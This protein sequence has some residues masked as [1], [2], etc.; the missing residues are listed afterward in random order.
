MDGADFGLD[1]DHILLATLG[2]VDDPDD[3]VQLHQPAPG[4]FALVIDWPAAAL[5]HPDLAPWASTPA[6]N[7]PC[8][9]GATLTACSR[10]LICA[11]RP[12]STAPF[13]P[14]RR[15]QLDRAGREPADHRRHQPRE[16]QDRLRP[17]PPNKACRD[18]RSVLYRR[19]PRLFEALALA[20]GDGRYARTLKPIAGRTADPRRLGPRAAHR[21]R[22]PRPAR[23]PRTATDAPP[24]SSPAS[25]RSTPGTTSS[26]TPPLPTPSST[27]S[28]KTPTASNSPA[29]ACA[30]S[31]P[32]AK[33]LTLTSRPDPEPLGRGD[34]PSSW[35]GR[36]MRGNP[37]PFGARLPEPQRVRGEKRPDPSKLVPKRGA[38]HLLAGTSAAV[39]TSPD[40]S[41]RLTFTGPQ[42]GR[43]AMAPPSGSG[44][45]R[46]RRA[47]TH[48]LRTA[49]Q[50]RPPT[51]HCP[52]GES[53]FIS[54]VTW[55]V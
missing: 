39:H 1:S 33:C 47:S 19:V 40:R 48:R 36:P 23:D 55:M 2:H 27:G 7:C 38:L 31:R 14:S 21:R 42:C 9:A 22:T 51:S 37:Q 13:R 44:R 49:A 6:P 11:R 28:S 35:N 24:P 41:P 3:P 8:P 43:S 10:T 5:L 32:S 17:W 16:K 45:R 46:H 34:R 12:A 53:K 15:W 50:Q 18:G 30:S 54:T 26:A 20:R 29:R 4:I 52:N 25:S